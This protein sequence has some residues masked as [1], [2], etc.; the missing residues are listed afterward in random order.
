VYTTKDGRQ[1]EIKRVGT[2][3]ATLQTETFANNSQPFY[4][5]LSPDGKLLTPTEQYNPN[6]DKYAEWLRCGLEA[7]S[8]M[9]E[10]N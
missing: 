10:T 1:K 8:Q 4:A 2:K 6:A 7:H 3:W 9:N 5:L